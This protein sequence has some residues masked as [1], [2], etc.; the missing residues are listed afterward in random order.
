MDV[1]PTKSPTVLDDSG[2]SIGIGGKYAFIETPDLIGVDFD[3]EYRYRAISGARMHQ[4]G[5]GATPALHIHE[6]FR[7]YLPISLGYNNFSPESSGFFFSTGIGVESE[8]FEDFSTRLSYKITLDDLYEINALSLGT[9]YWFENGM[10]IGMD[11]DFL[12]GQQSV[13]GTDFR[14]NF[15]YSF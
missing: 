3:Y 15:G 7:P 2:L 12:S 8:W 11:V 4:F 1:R 10:G 6:F 14:L 9:S 13:K 5:I